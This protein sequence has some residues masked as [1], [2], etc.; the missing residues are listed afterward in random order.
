MPKLTVGGTVIPGVTRAEVRIVHN[1]PKAPDPVPMM[2]WNITTRL[3]F[4]DFL[5][6]W[7]MAK[8]DKTRWKKSD[9]EIYNKDNSLAHKWSLLNSYVASYSEVEHPGG[10]ETVAGAGEGGYFLNIVIRGHMQEATDYTGI[11]VQ[12]VAPGAAPANAS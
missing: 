10:Q 3:Q 8:Q 12:T 1:N 2:E 6:L 4:S 11:N 5:P 9:L 7:A